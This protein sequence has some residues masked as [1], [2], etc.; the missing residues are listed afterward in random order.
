[1]SLSD[2]FTNKIFKPLG[3]ND[4]YFNIPAS[5]ANRLVNL[6]TEDADG[7]LTIVTSSNLLNGPTVANYPLIP[8]TYF[9]GGAGL[10]ST[11]YDYAIFLQMLLH[12]GMYNGKTILSRNSVRMMTMNQ[13]GD[14]PFGD[15][16]FGLGFEIVTEKGSSK[17]PAQQGTYSW[18]GAFA[19]SYWV[20]PKEKMVLLF[21][22]QLQGGSH[23]DVVNK[24]RALTY[25]A[26]KD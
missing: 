25:Q 12:N 16:K 4:T 22:R 23:G 8:H 9:S 2:Y 21:Y 18:G 11:I 24:F 10:S 5:K 26:I 3:M 17:F 14:I 7:K 6:Y 20:D 15:N 13:I 19:T 1:M